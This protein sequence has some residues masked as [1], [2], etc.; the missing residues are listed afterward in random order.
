MQAKS[1]TL[2]A[3]LQGRPQPVYHLNNPPKAHNKDSTTTAIPKGDPMRNITVTVSDEVP[4]RGA[5]PS[6]PAAIRAPTPHPP[7]TE[8]FSL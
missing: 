6:S 7:K 8:Y 2:E 1:V 4:P 3:N 5:R